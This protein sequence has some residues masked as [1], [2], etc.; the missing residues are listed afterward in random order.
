MAYSVHTC[1]IFFETWVQLA[2]LWSVK[3]V[4]LVCAFKLFEV[5]VSTLFF[6]V[7]FVCP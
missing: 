1:D 3:C 4:W 5:E 6:M 2:W 7:V